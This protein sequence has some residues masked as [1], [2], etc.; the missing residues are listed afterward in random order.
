MEQPK[1]LTKNE[2]NAILQSLRAGTVP[3]VGLKQI[4]VGREEEA[5]E[6][7]FFHVIPVTGSYGDIDKR[8]QASA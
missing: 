2:M 7:R 4:V 8:K 5:A 6:Q 3:K 1:K